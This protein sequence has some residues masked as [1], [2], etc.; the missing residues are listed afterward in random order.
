MWL[1]KLEL[2]LTHRHRSILFL[3]LL[4]QLSSREFSL[5]F[6]I[7]PLSHWSVLPYHCFFC[8]LSFF[9]NPIL[10]LLIASFCHAEVLRISQ[11]R[12]S[13]LFFLL[14]PSSQFFFASFL[15]LWK[16]FSQLSSLQTLLFC[17]PLDL[18]FCPLKTKTHTPFVWPFP[19][20]FLLENISLLFFL[21]LQP[22]DQVQSLGRAVTSLLST[23]ASQK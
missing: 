13:R 10:S 21:L 15:S 20:S 12:L 4:L 6:R 11:E 23:A 9:H 18:I 16:D 17:Q 14:L 2:H 1:P 22:G 8:F 3:Q 19:F 5:V 7:S